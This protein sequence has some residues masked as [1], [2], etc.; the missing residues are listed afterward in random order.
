M[1]RLF[2]ILIVPIVAF[3]IALNIIGCNNPAISKWY[4]TGSYGFYNFNSNR[5]VVSQ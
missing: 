4:R 5:H 1:V 2:I 3:F